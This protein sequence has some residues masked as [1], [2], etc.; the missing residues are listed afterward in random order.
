MLFLLGLEIEIIRK[1]KTFVI[2]EKLL[3]KFN[4]YWIFRWNN[5]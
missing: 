3:N 5:S 4:I 1:E 2:K